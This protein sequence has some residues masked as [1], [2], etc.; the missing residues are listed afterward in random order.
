MKSSA[1]ELKIDGLTK[2]YAVGQG[3]KRALGGVSFSLTALN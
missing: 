2:V 1:N 3:A